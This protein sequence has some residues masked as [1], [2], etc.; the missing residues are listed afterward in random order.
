MRAKL[1]VFLSVLNL[2]HMRDTIYHPVSNRHSPFIVEVST[3][4]PTI[5]DVVDQ[6]KK[7]ECDI[8]ATLTV[9]GEMHAQCCILNLF[10]QGNLSRAS[11]W[12]GNVCVYSL[13]PGG[14]VFACIL[15]MFIFT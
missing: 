11:L 4:L 8:D 12:V 9:L 15:F 6:K 14:Y 13:P 5:I 1:T 10:I 7:D 2:R 3:L